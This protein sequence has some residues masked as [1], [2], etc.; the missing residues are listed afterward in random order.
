MELN[1]TKESLIQ[2]FK[3]T[4]RKSYEHNR[5]W[6]PEAWED[7]IF[8]NKAIYLDANERKIFEGKLKEYLYDG[9]GYTGKCDLHTIRKILWDDTEDFKDEDCLDCLDTFFP[10]C[11]EN[12]DRDYI[13]DLILTAEQLGNYE[14]DAQATI[15]MYKDMEEV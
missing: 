12:Y 1:F 13:H 9:F 8:W 6:T 4:E 10:H 3:E 5:D 2:L 15:N 7:E 11:S 14:I